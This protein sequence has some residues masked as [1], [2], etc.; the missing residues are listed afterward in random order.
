EKQRLIE[1]YPFFEAATIPAGTYR[2]QDQPFMGMVVGFTHLIAT[3][4]ADEET[5][6]QFTKILYEHREEVVKKHR[7]GRAINAKN[8]VKDTGTPFHPGA[9]RYYKEIG[10]WPEQPTSA[11]NASAK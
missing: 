5:V 2:G 6:Y 11:S 9:I 4:S 1:Q 10:I 8:V 3:E 7:A